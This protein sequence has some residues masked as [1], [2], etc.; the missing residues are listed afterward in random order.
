MASPLRCDPR[1]QRPAPPRP[2]PLQAGPARRATAAP[3]AHRPPP[4]RQRGSRR[5]VTT[6]IREARPEEHAALGELVVTAYRLPPELDKS[7]DEPEMR[8]VPP[9]SPGARTRTTSRSC[10]T[11]L[12]ERARPWSWS[13]WTI[14]AEPCSAASPTCR[15]PR[16]PGRSCSSRARPGSGCWPWTRRL[17]AAASG[18]RWPRRASHGRGPTAGRHLSSTRCDHMR[19]AQAIYARLGFT[20]RPDRDWEPVPG[21]HLIGF[22]LAL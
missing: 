7:D 11:W 22:A 12:G 15:D 17:V 19:A 3:A 9:T 6:M 14:P 1:L 18:R 20:R 5:R 10:A 21:V 2:A 8:D 4:P 16:A 13:R